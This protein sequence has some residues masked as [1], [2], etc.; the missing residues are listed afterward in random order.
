MN[1]YDY[2]CY[3]FFFG[4]AFSDTGIKIIRRMIKK[5]RKMKN[6]KGG[7]KDEYILFDVL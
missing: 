6:K 7:F 5:I 2:F 4:V 3:G 1:A